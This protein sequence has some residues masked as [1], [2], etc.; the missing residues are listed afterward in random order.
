MT[1]ELLGSVPVDIRP[2]VLPM[3]TS[4]V[5]WTT[6]CEI[7]EASYQHPIFTILED[8]ERPAGSTGGCNTAAGRRDARVQEKTLLLDISTAVYTIKADVQS[9]RRAYPSSRLEA[10]R[11]M[12]VI[13]AS[14]STEFR[15][16]ARVVYRNRC[17]LSDRRLCTVV[18]S[19]S[20]YGKCACAYLERL[21]C[22]SAVLQR[23]ALPAGRSR[24][25]SIVLVDVGKAFP[26]F[27]VTVVRPTDDVEI[28][29]GRPDIGRHTPMQLVGIS[30]TSAVLQ[31][32][33]SSHGTEY[34]WPPCRNTIGTRCSLLMVPFNGGNV[35]PY[36]ARAYM[37]ICGERFKRYRLERYCC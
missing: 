4:S 18:Y 13:T 11:G 29:R 24:S 27:A 15:N 16:L 1:Y 8:R 19:K 25:S 23:H 22:L 33:R 32:H 28:G 31:V 5:G 37:T 10:R 6:D 30:G 7:R 2:A 9:V 26:Y 35:I 34:T 17:N 21:F 36:G 3:S 20:S 14:R 12:A